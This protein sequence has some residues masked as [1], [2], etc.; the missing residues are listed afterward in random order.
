MRQRTKLILLVS[1]ML[2]PAALLAENWPQW[3][4]P[5][6]DGTSPEK[7][8]PTTWSR[9]ENVA[10]QLPLPGPAG[11]TPVVWKD[12]IFLTSATGDRAGVDVVLICASTSGKKLWTRKLGGGNE[13]IRRGEGNSASP[14]PMTDGKYVWAFIGTGELACFDFEG[15]LV[16]NT[17]LQERY[18]EYDHWHGMSS[19]PVLHGD[20]LY[21]MCLRMEKPYLVALDKYTGKQRWKRERKSNA[22]HESRHSYASPILY[23]DDEQTLLLV[24]GADYLTA[25]RLEDGAEV[26][27]CGSLN[28]RENYHRTLR[29]VASPVC[30]PGLVV[31]PSA[32]KGPVVGVRP[33]GK[34]D[35][36]ES[37]R[38]WRRPRDTTDVPTPAIHDGLIYLLR[39]NGFLICVEAKTGKEIYFERLHPRAGIHR[40]SPVVADGNVYC[41]ARNGTVRVVRAG[42]KFEVLATNSMGEIT[43]STP[44]VSGGR[45]YLRTSKALYAIEASGKKPAGSASN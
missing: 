23:R 12:R 35:V 22:E 7:G 43:T 38:L 29:F 14:S 13:I 25:H 10:W 17:N 1:L 2:L 15:D 41:V 36:T 8:L 24:H 42:R 45:L 44:V 34:G 21:Q 31:A 5:N 9:T 26:W 37:H 39:E 16:W 32:K 40:A 6:G 20:T 4:G 28:P 19:T 18:G 3:R 30:V 27:R 33:D 11:A